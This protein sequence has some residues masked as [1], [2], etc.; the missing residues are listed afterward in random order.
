MRVKG[1]IRSLAQV[2]LRY[3]IGD[4]HHCSGPGLRND[5]YC[6]E[7]DVKLYYNIPCLIIIIIISHLNEFTLVRNVA[8]IMIDS[9][10]CML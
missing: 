1:V 9:G 3:R 10:R 7:C 2:A 4:V 5:L 8:V 6:V